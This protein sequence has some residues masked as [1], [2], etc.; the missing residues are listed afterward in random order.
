VLKS[1]QNRHAIALGSYLVLVILLTYPLILY[2]QTHVPGQGVDDPAQTWSLWWVRYALLNLGISPL[3]TDYL[4]YPVG[5]NLV[6]YTPTFLNGVLSI[7]LQLVFDVIPAAN[8]IVYFAFV[9]SGY[10]AFLLAREIL[11]RQRIDSDIA[12]MLAG[13]FFAFGAWHVHYADATYMLLSCEWIPFYVLYLFRLERN[14]VRNGT[15]AG[16]F[17]LLNAW[18]E[19]TLAM[20]LA[21]FTVLYLVGWFVQRLFETRNLSALVRVCLR[22]IQGFILLGVIALIGTSPLLYSLFN[23]T[24]R[25][26]YYLAQGMGRV[27]IFSAELVSFLFP[28]PQNPILGAWAKSITTANTRYAFIGY[29]ALVFVIIGFSANR[30]S[31]GAIFWGISTL[32]FASLMLGPSLIVAGQTTDV[33]MPFALLRAIPFVNANRYPVRFNTMLMFSLTP[34]IALGAARVLQSSRG[35]I[36][37]G[38]LSALLM[39]EQ[40]VIPIPLSD[41]RVPAIFETIRNDPGDFAVLNVPLGWRGSVSLQGKMEDPAQFFQTVHTKRMLGGITSRTPRFKTQYFLEAPVIQSMIALES[42]NDVDEHRRAL[43]RNNAAEVLRFFN[44]RYVNVN[45]AFAGDALTQ[46]I[47]DTFPLT[48]IYRD[49]TRTIYRVNAS[50]ALT[51]NRI[52]SQ[53]ET[54]R[55]Y[56]DDRWGRVQY[57]EDD[58]GYRWATQ[59]ES[60]IWLPL[61][62]QDH[63]VTFRIRGTRANQRMVLRVNGTLVTAL[64]LN[65]SWE[66]Y[67]VPI[68]ALVLRDGLDELVFATDTAFIGATRQDSYAIGDT[69]IV[70]PVDISITGA[71]FEAGR[72]GEIFVAGKSSVENKRGY[73]LVA[74]NPQ[75]GA[76][77]RIGSFD[78]FADINESVRLAKFVNDL[79]NGAI[80]AGVA[81]DDVSKNLSPAAVN[82]LHQLGV[83]ADLRFEFRAG[84][85]FIGVKGAPMGSVLESV[86]GRLPANVSVG[87]NVTS[88]R[89][90]FA[91]SWIEFDR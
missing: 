71:G 37:A 69:G 65:D 21:I 7:P 60:A 51:S 58:A 41:L 68:S 15:L 91:L 26:G 56:F 66:E 47:L 72:F 32:V 43:D 84:H 79:P 22:S 12:A 78:T 48:E 61:D 38:A 17:L 82:A 46:Y 23:D 1:I 42:G 18:T 73:Q 28:S 27:Q 70:S 3:T 31:R 90:S 39:I 30:K 5:I 4:F 29:A 89:V 34:L 40:L 19:L 13:A 45:R 11:H 14:P 88:D 8:F 62:E 33:P 20:F 35:K 75:S 87:K 57:F 25:F 50:P 10:G 44:I 6:A 64:V 83:E 36:I 49:D 16:F 52:I 74:I 55:L 53:P 86:E 59:G 77:E 2:F 9:M 63:T 67:H 80:V 54:A 76:V 24:Q 85:A 81:I